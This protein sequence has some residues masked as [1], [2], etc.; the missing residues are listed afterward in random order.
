MARACSGFPWRTD[1]KAHQSVRHTT[2]SQKKKP[3]S[4]Y[5]SKIK[6]VPSAWSTRANGSS[7][8]VPR[9]RLPPTDVAI[10]RDNEM[11]TRRR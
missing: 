10:L 11:L 1:S 6:C 4:S 8:H 3:P 2:G 9:W 7:D 5:E